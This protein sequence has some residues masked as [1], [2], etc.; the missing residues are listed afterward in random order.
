[1]FRLSHLAGAQRSVH[2]SSLDWVENL[3]IMSRRCLPLCARRLASAVPARGGPPRARRD[4]RAA[5]ALAG[6]SG[7]GHRFRRGCDSRD[8]HVTSISCCLLPSHATVTTN[9]SVA[10]VGTLLRPPLVAAPVLPAAVTGPRQLPDVSLQLLALPPLLAPPLAR[11]DDLRLQG[12]GLLRGGPGLRLELRQKGPLPGLQ[13]PAAAPTARPAGEVSAAAPRETQQQVSSEVPSIVG[14]SRRAAG[15]GASAS[16]Q[17]HSE[18]KWGTGQRHL[19]LTHSRSVRSFSLRASFTISLTKSSSRR[20]SATS[21][22]GGR[23][24]DR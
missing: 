12:L 13:L 17:L 19:S 21:R 3:I 16:C 18:M 4:F 7:A 15:D 2:S 24:H 23:R 10:P 20:K 6:S 8:G 22:R 5:G 11:G 14:G 1:M 9:L